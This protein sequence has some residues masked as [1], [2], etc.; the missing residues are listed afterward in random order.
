MTTT[1]IKNFLRQYPKVFNYLKAIQALL[2]DYVPAL[3]EGDALRKNRALCLISSRCSLSRSL[4]K[5]VLLNIEPTTVCDQKCTICETGLGILGRKP[6][7]M[8]IG[9]YQKILDQF[10][11]TMQEII[12]YFMGETFLNKDAYKMIRYAANKGIYVSTCT[13]GNF[14]APLA[15]VQSGI[16]EI[17]FHIA[18]TTQEIHEIY[19]VGGTLETVLDATRDTVKIRN[20]MRDQLKGNPYPM[21]ISLGFILFK[22][23][24]H[25]V[26]DLQELAESLGVDNYYVIDPCVRNIEQGHE[27]LPTD[28]D[29][30]VYDPTA[31]EQGKLQ[32]RRPP[33]NECEW[34][35]SA[36]TIQVNGDVVPCCR[37]PKGLHVLGNALEENLYSIWN[38]EAYRTLRKQ[39]TT[40]QDELP[41]CNLCEGYVMPTKRDPK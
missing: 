24:E 13:N 35:Y 41:L 10:D 30:W 8:S 1:K 11:G 15:L 40:I 20:E 14:T 31:Y 34:L 4:G 12:L 16:A 6:Q 26:P 22:H 18:G 19:R 32:M 9:T 39:V 3:M 2:Y 17:N 33:H 38:N 29:H 27:L 23:N 5:P 36:M 28:K 21:R 25:Q 7:Y 37:D